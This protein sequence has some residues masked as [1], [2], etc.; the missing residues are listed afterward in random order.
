LPIDFS[1]REFYSALNEDGFR[2]FVGKAL[3]RR[4]KRNFPKTARDSFI[5]APFGAAMTSYY[6]LQ[7]RNVYIFHFQPFLSFSWKGLSIFSNR[8][9][10]TGPSFFCSPS[11][12]YRNIFSFSRHYLHKYQLVKQYIE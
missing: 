3:P 2:Q 10:L 8:R 1:F 5:H 7:Q 4:A 12:Q 6:C 9:I 11:I